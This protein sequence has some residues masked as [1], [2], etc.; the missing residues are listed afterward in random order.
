MEYSFIDKYS[1]LDSP[2]HRLDPRVKIISALVFVVCVVTTAPQAFPQFLL[3]FAIAAFLAVLAKVPL[4]FILKRSLAVLP[5]VLVVI[6]FLPF[7]S[8]GSSIGSLNIGFTRLAVSHKGLWIAWN[9][10]IKSWLSML[11]MVLLASTTG[12]QMVLKGLERL[13]VPRIFL[14]ILSFMYRY[15]F[16][17]SEAAE[18]MERARRMRYFGGRALRQIGVIGNMIGMLFIR[19]YER[20]ERIYLGMCARGFDGQIRTLSQLKL[21]S[22]DV[23]CLILF[24]AALFFIRIM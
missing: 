2:V 5:F 6:I 9:V 14:M 20:G 19:S 12:F 23:F 4:S 1:D 16:V 22:R 3:F 21:G 10:L 15:T 18:K 11:A 7:A 17:I 8:G 24:S 13:R